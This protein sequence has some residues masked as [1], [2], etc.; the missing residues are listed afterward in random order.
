MR[1]NDVAA[2]TFTFI[3]AGGEGRRLS[4][5][6]RHRPKPAVSFGGM[7]RIIDFTLSNCLHSGIGRVS[8]VTQYRHE[9]LYRYIRDGWS[10]LW[11]NA[12]QPERS[13]L[14][15]LP[16]MSGNRYRGTADAVFQNSALLES[17][18]AELVLVLSGD[19]I[20]Q[21]DYRD[22]LRQHMETGADLTIGTVEHPLG[23]A[24]HFGVV[25]VD[26]N[27]MVTGFEEKPENP[28]PLPS[29]P[30]MALV[31]MGV[32]VFKKTVILES[33]RRL[34]GTAQG[35]DF[36]HDIIPS[37]IRSGRTYAYDFR[38]KAQVSPRYWRDIGT[39]D[40]YY[41]A[42]MD[43]VAPYRPFDPYANDGWPSQ[44]TRYPVLMGS[45]EARLS[46]GSDSRVTRSVLSPD[47]HLEEG[48][49]VADSVLM[50]GVRIG[51]G[52]RL[53]RTIVEE[54]VHVPAGFQAG[55][56]LDQD[57]EHHTVTEAGVV[58]VSQTPANSKPFALRFTSRCAIRR[59]AKTREPDGNRRVTV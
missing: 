10:D 4:P 51:Q 49:I 58:V 3:L 34:C 9:E 35:Y 54:G 21:M 32:Y 23:G 48:V 36:G 22:F 52:A 30:S 50:P 20:Y 43:L 26:Q 18:S 39:V 41:E 33:L 15:F 27:L 7:F 8:L 14:G 56:D 29:R 44:P 46:P 16:A 42:S 12:G 25:E 59:A 28:R 31:S 47:V 6:T 17:D 19:H 38:D 5:L 13:P 55:F 1:S 53:Q 40:A 45:T 57:L 37:L 11:N 2:R 24:S